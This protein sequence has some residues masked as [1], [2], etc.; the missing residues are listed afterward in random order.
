MKSYTAEYDDFEQFLQYA[1]KDQNIKLRNSKNL[2]RL[3][4]I[5]YLTVNLNA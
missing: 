5:Q 4:E 3:I 2:F 1:I